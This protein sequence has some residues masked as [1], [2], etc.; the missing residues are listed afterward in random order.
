MVF[1][2][3]YNVVARQQRKRKS[4]ALTRLLLSRLFIIP[5]ELHLQHNNDI[6]ASYFWIGEHCFICYQESVQ[7]VLVHYLK[8]SIRLKHFWYLRLITS[9]MKGFHSFS[10]Y[11][12]LLKHSVKKIERLS[13][14]KIICTEQMRKYK[15]LISSLYRVFTYS[16]SEA[17]LQDKM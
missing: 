13:Y 16:D 5:E 17:K 11:R 6:H 9:I 1:S 7:I 15:M 12:S 8:V 3:C 2:W 14:Q 10:I 4:W